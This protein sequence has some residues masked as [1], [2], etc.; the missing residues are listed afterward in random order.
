M[1]DALTDIARDERRT[2]AAGDY[3]IAVLNHLQSSATPE[4]ASAVIASAQHCDDIPPGYWQGSTNF[5]ASAETT[6]RGLEQADRLAWARTLSL[7][8]HLFIWGKTV[9]KLLALSPWPDKSMVEV[10]FNYHRQ[11]QFAELLEKPMHAAGNGTTF[12]GNP[13]GYFTYIV[14]FDDQSTL[15]Q[16]AQSAICIDTTYT[17]W[18]T[19][20]DSPRLKPT[21]H[22]LDYLQDRAKHFGQR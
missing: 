9:S 22:R 17:S 4:S 10:A 1:S 3:I 18:S 7:A 14:F 5:A 21:S 13:S 19:G 11:G 15:L 12:H 16:I 20:P 8:S 2:N 6:L